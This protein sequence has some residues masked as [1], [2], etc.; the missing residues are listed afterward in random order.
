MGQIIG[1]ACLIIIVALAYAALAFAVAAFLVPVKKAKAQHVTP[2]PNNCRGFIDNSCCC[3]QNCCRTIKGNEIEK[4]PAGGYRVV[5]TKAHIERVEPSQ[6]GTLILCDC[7]G[8]SRA[9]CLY[10]PPQT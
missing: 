9:Y 2:A 6:D 10:Y 5:K 8:G 1:K 7:T 3:S 4:D